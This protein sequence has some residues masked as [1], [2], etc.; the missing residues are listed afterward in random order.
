[1]KRILFTTL[2]A[3]M[4]TGLFAQK[5][6]KAK[7]LLK[8]NK[9]AEAKTEIDNFLAQEKNQKNAD[10][11]YTKAKIYSA[12]SMDANAKTQF[13][14]TRM[15]GF[16]ALKKYT[17]LDDKMLIAL[18]IDGYKPVNEMYTGAYQ[19]A[20]NSFNAKNYEQAYEGFKNAIAVSSFMTQKGWINLKLDTNSTLYAGVAAEKLG[21]FEDAA[22]YYGK[23]VE[24]KAKGEGFVEIYK[25]VANHYFE[26]KD[27][28]N[29][30]KYLAIGK[31]V[32][33]ADP[34]WAQLD[35]DMARE[36]GDKAQLFTKYEE[37]IAA[38]PNNHLYRYNYAVEL[39]QHGYNQDTAK[40]PAD[41]EGFIKKAQESIQAAIRIKP[42]YSKA[43]LFA[44]QIAYNQGVDIL[45]RSK[46][47]K[48]TAAADVKRKADLK[49]EAL[50]KFDE[51]I[52][53]FI[54]V[55]NLLSPQGKLKM[56]DKSDLKE[57]LDLLITIYD[58]KGMKDKVKE[59]EVKFN[60]VDRKH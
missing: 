41:S 50:K 4:V 22:S 17:E 24:S 8:S 16:E 5:V 7:E 55:D 48:G 47:I 18:Q 35:V 11:W 53:Y 31:E 36:K 23:L 37:T 3:A 54:E 9:L 45:T 57:A 40:R 32:Y 46:A 10:A 27:A 29:A 13:P 39:Y 42:D 60:D 2:F 58:Q 1:M 30:E 14:N 43:Q 26:K 49:A 21:K 20:A 51:A 38:N 34:F 19:E 15:E 33:P 12:I 28:A 6:E 59:Y 44:G 52:P 25:W 56:E